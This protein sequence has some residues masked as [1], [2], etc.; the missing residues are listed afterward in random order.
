MAFVSSSNNNS[1]NGTVN[2]AQAVN[3]AFGISTIGTQVNTTNLDNLSDAVICAF[4][5]S[6][7]NWSDQAEEGPNY[8]LMAYTSTSS[9]SKVSNDSTCSK[10]Y[11][12]YVKLLKS[13]NEQLL[14]DLKKSELM[15]LGYKIAIKE[16]RRK[17]EVALKEIEEIQLTVE[18]LENAS[19]SLN[20]LID[21]QIVDNCKKG[22]EYES[23]NALSPP[24]TGN[25]M[26]LKPNLSYIKIDEFVVKPIVKN[27]SSKEET[28]AIRKNLDAPIVEDW[29]LDDEEEN[30]TQP[31]IAI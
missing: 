12:E 5:A 19:K 20:K 17:L 28:K 13:Q 27:K 29:V 9:D 24:Y 22:L 6:Q 18:K 14:K 8:T 1:T 31:K 7:P 4:L 30:V 23:Y 11:L 25:F 26:P 21:Y 16:L 10:S 3:T 15:V 2:I